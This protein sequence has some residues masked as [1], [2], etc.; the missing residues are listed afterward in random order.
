MDDEET[1]INVIHVP[2]AHL[3]RIEV[4]WEPEIKEE[5]KCCNRI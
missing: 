4:I 3:V 1:T 5:N 2:I